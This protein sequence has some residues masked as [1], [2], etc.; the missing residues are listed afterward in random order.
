MASASARVVP[1]P[2]GLRGDWPVEWQS[3]AGAADGWWA[4][5]EHLALEGALALAL[6]A[7]CP[8]V[9][10]LLG[11]LA[12]LA[13]RVDRRHGRA[14]REYLRQAL[15]ELS[16]PELEHRVLLAYRHFFQVVVD[17]RRLQH[18]VQ[19]RD[20]LDHVSVRWSDEARRVA[21]SPHGKV[22]L[23]AHLGNWE[24]AIAALPWL[25]FDPLYFVAK[26]AR[27]RPMSVAIQ[28]ARERFGIRVLPRRGAMHSAARILHAGGTLV[29]LLDQRARKRPAIAPLFGRPARSDRSAHVLLRRFRAPLLLFAA[30]QEPGPLRWTIEFD[31]VIRPED[32][33]SRDALEVLARIHRAF[34]RM[35]R[36]NPD[37]YLWL[38][39]RYRDTPL[40]MGAARTLCSSAAASLDEE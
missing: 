21:A 34:E 3:V 25:G 15:G 13:R 37:Q 40:E 18:E 39:D 4:H 32:P 9:D 38:H 31:E 5:A 30:R 36:A 17:V 27:N 16:A 33:G 23:S 26:P 10:V 35:I 22:L 1:T 19:P 8:A 20:V 29:M 28:R 11:G 24:A 12:R 6:R 14:A 7:P 2:A